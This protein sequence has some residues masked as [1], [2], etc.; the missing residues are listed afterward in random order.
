MNDT[1]LA[2]VNALPLIV[3]MVPALPEVG[4]N[5]ETAGI[6]P[7]LVELV[8]LPSGVVTVTGPVS[9]PDGTV[10][11]IFVSDTTVNAAARPLNATELAPVRAL[12]LTVTDDP[13][14]AEDGETPE[15]AG[16]GWAVTVNGAELVPVP[17]G[18]VT[19]TG[20]VVAPGGTVAVVWLS[21]FTVKVAA[22]PLNI[23]EAAPV[24]ALP[25]I[26]TDDP[27]QPELG[28]NDETVGAGGGTGGGI[29]RGVAVAPLLGAAPRPK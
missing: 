15:T 1:E 12:P 23:T 20:P 11:V 27:G 25:L 21:E 29:G 6:T 17:E 19:E 5:E 24:K 16:A 3:T 13:T 10:A 22:A 7:K 8:V 9:A 2:P 28:V 18:V 14:V 26:V 4:L